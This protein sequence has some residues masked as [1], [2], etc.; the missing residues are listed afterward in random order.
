LKAYEA[1]AR[2]L[3]DCEVDPLFGLMG[4]GNMRYL[5]SYQELNKGRYVSSVHE[6]GAVAM[7]DG[8]AKMTGKLGVAS[9]THGP[10]VTNAMTAITEAARSRTPLLILTGET[11][12]DKEHRQWLDLRAAAH[13][14]GAAYRA[15]RSAGSMVDDLAAAMR[16]AT[17]LKRTVIFNAAVDLLDLPVDYAP[18]VFGALSFREP[19]I[20]P[21]EDQLDEAAGILASARRPVLLAG[22]GAMAANAKEQILA[23]ADV[24]QAPLATTVNAMNY[25]EGHPR[26]MG[27]F[28]T[29]AFPFVADYITQSD[30]VV[31]FGAGLNDFT[32]AKGELLQ[33]KAV[34][35]C[36]TDVQILASRYPSTVHALADAREFA[37]GLLA[38]M[39]L[40]GPRDA[41]NWVQNI[42]RDL[43]AY[44]PASDFKDTSRPGTVDMRLAMLA[45]SEVL[46]VERAYVTGIGR[47]KTAPWRYLSCPPGNF[48][49]TGGFAAV[50][51]DLATAIGVSMARPELT[52]VAIMGD[53]GLMMSLSEI[54]SAMQQRVRLVIV[55][56]NDGSYGAEYDKIADLGHDPKY[57]L[58]QYP[59]F[60]DIVRGFGMSSVTVRS[61]DEIRELSPLLA[62]VNEPILVEVMADPAVNILEYS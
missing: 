50:G 7:A 12:T 55:V 54:V 53:G 2:Y 23:L 38:R 52:T 17:S 28:G 39:N 61:L 6:A 29:E 51:L 58:V 44:D 8:Y 43:A 31:A 41:S 25:F 57:S 47:Y 35:Q 22:R 10:G 15:A 48:A 56:L 21:D 1:I 9:V 46:P 34:V 16:M 36:D 3:V 4:D 14:S 37:S 42:E 60:A 11:P 45:L 33:G 62:D 30:C 40:I 13:L 49:Q 32:T 26:Y 19:V 20:A 59:S 24:I 18:S 5:A 27:I